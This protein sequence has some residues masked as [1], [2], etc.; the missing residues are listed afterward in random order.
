MRSPGTSRA[1]LTGRELLTGSA[2]ALTGGTAE[3]GFASVW[4]RGAVSRF[5]G[6]EG[7]LT[8]EGEVASAM[9]GADFTRER[10]TVGLMVTHSRGEGS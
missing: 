8:L 5:D 9:L 3:S 2:F 4:G 6:R 7:E 1:R 10:G